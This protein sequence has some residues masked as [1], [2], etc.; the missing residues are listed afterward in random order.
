MYMYTKEKM[1]FTNSL[2]AFTLIVST[3]LQASS[4]SSFTASALAAVDAMLAPGTCDCRTAELNLKDKETGVTISANATHP[5]CTLCQRFMKQVEQKEYF[6]NILVTF[7][8]LSTDID[9]DK[10]GRSLLTPFSDESFQVNPHFLMEFS[11][12]SILQHN[13]L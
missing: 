2:H 7:V 5:D 10:P 4:Y 13:V 6:H 8:I 1:R 3:L 11:L 12:F 9:C